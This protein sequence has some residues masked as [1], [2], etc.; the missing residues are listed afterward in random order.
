MGE[1]VFSALMRF[2]K[3]SFACSAALVFFFFAN[4]ASQASAQ[5]FLRNSEASVSFLAQ[6]TSNVSGN[7]VTDDP[8]E[9]FGGQAS[10][11]HSYHWWLGFEGSY[12]YSR[13]SEHY[14]ARP[15]AV[16]HN[17]HEFA[18]S[19]LVNGGNFLG[20]RPFALAGVSELVFSPTLNGGQNVS[21]Q[22]E[23]ALNF[24]AGIDRALYTSHFG[25]RLQYRGVFAK[26]P[27]FGLAALD[28][29]KSRMTSEPM[30]GVY[31]HF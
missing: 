29:G 5:S 31:L 7:S 2:F 11:R 3:L 26:S 12:D 18:A 13:F 19:Y 17:T 4:F 6:S 10:F 20:F 21:W 14:S 28:T 1:E 22:G 23:P 30:A 8:T 16:Q 25:I 27:D 15:Y 24:G 9:S